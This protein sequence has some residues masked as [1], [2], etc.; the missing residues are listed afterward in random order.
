MSSSLWTMGQRCSVSDWGSGMS[1]SC[2]LLIQLFAD[3]GKDQITKK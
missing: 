3:K 2:K 1:A